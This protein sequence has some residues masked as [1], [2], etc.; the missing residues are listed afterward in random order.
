MQTY[1]LVEGKE[2]KKTSF[3][4]FL[5][6][7]QTH[8]NSQ[9]SLRIEGR[10]KQDSKK[11]FFTLKKSEKYSILKATTT[12]RICGVVFPLTL[13]FLTRVDFEDHVTAGEGKGR[14][15][16]KKEISYFPLAQHPNQIRVIWF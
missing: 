10:E 7:M 1:D 12:T 13:L 8:N 15:E 9:A 11:A 16:R 3:S 14:I 5:A 6:S 4:L 2:R